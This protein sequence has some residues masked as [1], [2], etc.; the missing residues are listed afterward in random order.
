MDS[1]TL[2]TL[3]I[4]GFGGYMIFKFWKTILKMLIGLLCFCV[5]YTYLSLKKYFDGSEKG[6]EKIE[7]VVE[8]T[9]KEGTP[10]YINE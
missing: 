9:V 4:L 6:K 10:T 5:V 2:G 8:E 7:Q 1:Q 3:A